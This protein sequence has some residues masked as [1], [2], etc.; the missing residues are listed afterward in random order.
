MNKDLIA[1][2]FRLARGHYHIHPELKISNVPAAE[3]EYVPPVQD[4]DPDNGGRFPPPPPKKPSNSFKVPRVASNYTVFNYEWL[5]TSLPSPTDP[6]VA[7]NPYEPPLDF[8][9]H[10][11]A[12]DAFA[13]TNPG[14]PGLVQ[15]P[16][17]TVPTVKVGT[18]SS[19]GFV[20]EQWRGLGIL[21]A[22]PLGSTLT[23]R[24]LHAPA[25]SYTA[26]TD[27]VT[28]SHSVGGATWVA[29]SS[30]FSF[31][32]VLDTLYTGNRF[33]VIMPARIQTLATTSTSYWLGQ[34]FAVASLFTATGGP[35]TS[36]VAPLAQLQT[37]TPPLPASTLASDARVYFAFIIGSTRADAFT[38]LTDPAGPPTIL[39][40]ARR[41]VVP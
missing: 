5:H 38:A 10:Q 1:R 23:M 30:A 18:T 37:T 15:R 35:V 26:S 34:R 14:A 36:G 20:K 16:A 40:T 41:I 24:N 9:D 4:P 12:Y 25:T 22:N 2:R 3:A 19:G 13:G 8:P 28:Y 7:K 33:L 6:N 17:Y 31:S 29:S 27:L 39:S 11:W 21:D 32:V